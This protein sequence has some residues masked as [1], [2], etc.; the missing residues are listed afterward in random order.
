MM[1]FEVD[2]NSSEFCAVNPAVIKVIG[3]GGGGGNAVNT[4]IDANVQGV[5]FIALNTD[6]QDLNKSKAGKKIQIGKKLS[7]GLGAGGDP[8]RGEEAAKESES[9]IRDALA[10]ANMVF[11]TA[12]MGGGTGTGSAPVVASIAKE[13][14][15]LTVAIV[16]Y[17][18]HFEK[19]KR[20]ENADLGIKKLQSEVDS[21]LVI[22]NQKIFEI[23]KNIPVKRAFQYVTDILRQ[24][25]QGI[26]DIIMKPGLINRDFRDVES[27]MKGQG[28]ALLGI[29]EGEGDNRAIDAATNAI[30]NPL[31]EG[32][33][34]D[35][36]QNI[37]INVSGGDDV[38]IDECEEIAKFITDRAA[39][40]ANVIWGLVADEN[41]KDQKLNVTVI[42]TGFDKK[43]VP[44]IQQNP[45]QSAAAKKRDDD[46]FTSE[47]FVKISTTKTAPHPSVTPVQQAPVQRQ[48]APVQQRAPENRPVQQAPVESDFVQPVKSVSESSK[49]QSSTKVDVNKV[50]GGSAI[51]EDDD[52]ANGQSM[53]QQDLM[54]QSRAYSQPSNTSEPQGPKSPR[55]PDDYVDDPQDISKPTWAREAYKSKLSGLGPGINLGNK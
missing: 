41:I 15:A 55:L 23:N 3:C 27:V 24:G 39:K 34:I 47:D 25:V 10:G 46:I 51:Y 1:D 44:S 21:L 5:E 17:P 9:E 7:G 45:A 43:E 53:F 35:G 40:S 11:I 26:S 37:L 38:T 48:S 50:L 32:N 31:L 18:F 29:G 49:P 33:N 8:S 14:G 2:N 28:K 20:A 6:G 16:T 42:A 54:A 4:M 36:A 19:S 30:S 12:G 13:L 52:S 22:P